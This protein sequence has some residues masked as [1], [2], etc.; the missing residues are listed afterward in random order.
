MF[1]GLPGRL[2][3]LW[4]VKGA[5]SRGRTF[6]KG[7]RSGA[8]RALRPTSLQ[9]HLA[10]VARPRRLDVCLRKVRPRQQQQL[11]YGCNLCIIY[12]EEST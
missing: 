7:T 12:T 4:D 3:R 1:V 10:T 2:K 9:N 11:S 5:E 6:A 8:L